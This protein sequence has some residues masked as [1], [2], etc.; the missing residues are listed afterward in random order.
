MEEPISPQ[1]KSPL[2]HSRSPLSMFISSGRDSQIYIWESTQTKKGRGSHVDFQVWVVIIM[3][4]V[5]NKQMKGK[6]ILF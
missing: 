2:L 5:I 6:G 4:R 1:T 3:Y